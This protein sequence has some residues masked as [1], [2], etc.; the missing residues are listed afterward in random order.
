MWHMY[1]YVLKHP[2]RQDGLDGLNIDQKL[3]YF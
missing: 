1:K 3:P 2:F